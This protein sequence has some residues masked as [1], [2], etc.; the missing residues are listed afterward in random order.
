MNMNEPRVAIRLS[1]AGL[2][3]AEGHFLGAALSESG[4]SLWD[5]LEAL[6]QRVWDIEMEHD[7]CAGLLSDAIGLPLAE[8]EVDDSEAEFWF[9]T[10]EPEDGLATETLATEAGSDTADKEQ[11]A[12]PQTVAND[13]R[14]VVRHLVWSCQAVD[15]EFVSGRTGLEA[16]LVLDVLRALEGE[17]TLGPPDPSGTWAVVRVP[18]GR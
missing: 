1:P 6:K 8:D 5:C 14:R 12:L 18:L 11:E 10:D 2:W 15:V 3:Q 16:A 7:A 4:K 13:L 17:G 9:L